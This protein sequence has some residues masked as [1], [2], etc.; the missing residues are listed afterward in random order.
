MFSETKETRVRLSTS[1][2]RGPQEH[3]P[4]QQTT[5]AREVVRSDSLGVAKNNHTELYM[6]K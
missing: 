6:D 3:Q 5:R 4:Q 1:M 2:P